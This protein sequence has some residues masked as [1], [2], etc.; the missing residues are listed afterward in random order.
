MAHSPNA[1]LWN[2]TEWQKK[3]LKQQSASFISIYFIGATHS[4]IFTWPFKNNKKVA[5]FITIIKFIAP[6]LST[7]PITQ[8]MFRPTRDKDIPSGNRW[9]N[10]LILPVASQ[11]I[12]KAL[13]KILPTNKKIYIYVKRLRAFYQ[14]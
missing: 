3:K 8:S 7:F 9:T 11:M 12:T 4:V 1:N 2:L 6:Q 5:E 13:W 10:A 14:V